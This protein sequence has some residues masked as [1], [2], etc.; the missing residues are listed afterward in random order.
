MLEARRS[1]PS[2]WNCRDYGGEEAGLL[3]KAQPITRREN[4]LALARLGEAANSGALTGL[5]RYELKEILVSYGDKNEH[6]GVF[7]GVRRAAPGIAPASTQLN[8][9]GTIDVKFRPDLNGN[10]FVTDLAHEG[11]HI[12]DAAY[13]RDNPYVGSSYDETHYDREYWAYDAGAHAAQALGMRGYPQHADIKVWQRG[14]TQADVAVAIARY[15]QRGYPD[16]NPGPRYS[17]EYQ[18]PKKIL[19]QPR[20]DR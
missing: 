5:Q 20:D 18:G 16:A 19:G 7:V 13:F 3:A 4:A 6:N 8:D 17:D 9:S 11:Q 10:D 1:T 12:S 2:T 15:I 14:W